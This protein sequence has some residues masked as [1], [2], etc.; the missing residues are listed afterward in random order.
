MRRPPAYSDSFL[1]IFPKY[2]LNEEPL[3][4]VVEPK[5]SLTQWSFLFVFKGSFHILCISVF[6]TTFY[7]L[8][9]N[10]SEDAGIFNTINTYYQPLVSGCAQWPNGTKW[11]VRELFAYSINASRID[12][13]GQAAASER[14][15][16]NRGLILQSSL[17]SVGTLLLCLGIVGVSFYKKWKVAW[18][19]IFLENMLFIGVLAAY[20]FFF[21][22]TIIY[23]YKTLSTAELN[24][25]IVDGLASCT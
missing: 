25:Y 2:T 5:E 8:Y 7:F 23:N 13:E 1:I 3:L 9:V 16:Y 6:E 11:L 22:N 21:Y 14:T 19:S 18:R 20:E 4:E 17:Y 24:R 12:T 10:K 15:A